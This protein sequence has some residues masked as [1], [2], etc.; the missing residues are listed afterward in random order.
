MIGIMN[1]QVTEPSNKCMKEQCK[2]EIIKC[3]LDRPKQGSSCNEIISSCS[4][5]ITDPRDYPSFA[6]CV[7]RFDNCRADNIVL[8]AYDNDCDVIDPFTS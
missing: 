2:D 4:R 7:G 3:S 1:C 8:C 6:F 5:K